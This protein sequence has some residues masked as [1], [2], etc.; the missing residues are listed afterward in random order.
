MSG[1]ITIKSYVCYIPVLVVV[2]FLLLFVCFL[3]FFLLVSHLDLEFP[4]KECPLKYI[5]YN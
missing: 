2:V 1:A 5:K 4:G 3:G